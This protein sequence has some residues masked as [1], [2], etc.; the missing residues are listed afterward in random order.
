MARTDDEGRAQ[1]QRE[2]A[3][4]L[5]AAALLDL[6]ALLRDPAFVRVTNRWLEAGAMFED[7]WSREPAERDYYAGRRSLAVTIFKDL[8]DAR[9]PE[10]PYERDEPDPDE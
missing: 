5:E 10:V 1:Q 7:V 6:R 2:R 3:R 8:E 4:R 9:A